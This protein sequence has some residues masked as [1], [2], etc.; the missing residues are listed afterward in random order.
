[1]K[2]NYQ[3]SLDEKETEKLKKHLSTQG[4]TFSGYMNVIVHELLSTFE[5]LDKN[6]TAIRQTLELFTDATEKLEEAK[7]TVKKNKL[8][9]VK[10]KGKK[11]P[12]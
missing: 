11:K 1:M 10:D 12:K 3:L 5:N 7:E 9:Q 2:K 4:Y 8:L 6:K